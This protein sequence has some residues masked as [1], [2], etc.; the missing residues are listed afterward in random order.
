MRHLLPSCAGIL[1]ACFA[2]AR[3][4]SAQPAPHVPTASEAQLLSAEDARFKAELTHDAAALDRS[5]ASD[6]VYSHFNGK[7]EDKSEVM[8]TFTHL[9]F[10]S[11]KP[12]NRQA[13]VI[14]DVGIV[15]GQVVR[16]LGDRTLSDGYLAVY[17]KRD[18]RWQLIEW[19]SA[20]APQASSAKEASK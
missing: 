16:Q 15:R 17:A 2:A 6:V 1:I 19:V 8:Q 3:P 13:R 14:G 5:T 4:A 10:S 20:S 18:G 11:I 9:P 12:S 7:R